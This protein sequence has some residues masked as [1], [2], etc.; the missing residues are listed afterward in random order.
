M[1]NIKREKRNMCKGVQAQLHYSC[2]AIMQWTSQ[3]S[4]VEDNSVRKIN[5]SYVGVN[6]R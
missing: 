1:E 6:E 2:S 4:M 3:N 5:S